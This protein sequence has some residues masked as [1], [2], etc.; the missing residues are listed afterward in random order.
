MAERKNLLKSLRRKNIVQKMTF[1]VL[2]IT[3]LKTV[4]LSV[5]H[6]DKFYSSI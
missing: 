1:A 2:G 6:N 4:L 5:F 3:F